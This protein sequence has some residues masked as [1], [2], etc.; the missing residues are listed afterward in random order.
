MM[1]YLTVH[2]RFQ[3]VLISNMNSV[4]KV[5]TNNSS[6][7]ETKSIPSEFHNIKK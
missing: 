4:I 6:N 5:P 3:G 7:Q 1:G 2:L